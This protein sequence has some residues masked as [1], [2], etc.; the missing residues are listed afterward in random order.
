MEHGDG[1]L[2]EVS[3]PNAGADIGKQARPSLPELAQ[4]DKNE[5]QTDGS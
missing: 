5:S 4:R 3:A 2:Y 1:P